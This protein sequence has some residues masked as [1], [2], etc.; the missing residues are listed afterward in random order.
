MINKPEVQ[1][2]LQLLDNMKVGYVIAGGYPRD[3]HHGVKPNDLDIF[4]LAPDQR[5]IDAVYLWGEVNGTVL[6]D[7]EY[8][9]DFSDFLSF[10]VLSDPKEL[11]V[12]IILT[13]YT[14][15]EQVWYNF[16]YN[17]NQYVLKPVI[18]CDG[19]KWVSQFVGT[20]EKELTDLNP[21]NVERQMKMYEK[22]KQLG[23]TFRI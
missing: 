18:D 5:Q 11:K 6:N 15:P 13:R 2:L 23:W 21:C 19:V 9:A 14:W 17:I 4:L 22:A 3:I 7:G 8:E 12:N 10:K 20:H 16:D 1:Q